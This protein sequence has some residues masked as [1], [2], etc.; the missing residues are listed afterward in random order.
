[1]LGYLYG[2]GGVWSATHRRRLLPTRGAR[3]DPDPGKESS[4]IKCG[5]NESKCSSLFSCFAPIPIASMRGYQVLVR[6]S[7]ISITSHLYSHCSSL[8]TGDSVSGPSQ[9][10][11]LARIKMQAACSHGL[12][13]VL[14]QWLGCATSC[15]IRSEAGGSSDVPSPRTTW[16]PRWR[17]TSKSWRPVAV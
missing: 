5:S 17:M 4:G 3:S 6:W 11:E 7:R 1:M 12:F 2:S 9:T 16:C 8:F 15:R 14:S 13:H 10:N